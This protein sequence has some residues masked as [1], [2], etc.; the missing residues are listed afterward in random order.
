[1]ADQDQVTGNDEPVAEGDDFEP[2][3]RM[4]GA[5]KPAAEGAG[6]DFE[7]HKRMRAGD[8]AAAEDDDDVELHKKM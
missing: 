3:K 1:V 7:L 8:E 2:H 5:D 4:K 6:D